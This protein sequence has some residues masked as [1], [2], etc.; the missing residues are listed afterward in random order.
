MQTRMMING[1]LE[2]G[3]G[4]RIPV[5]NPATG[6]ELVRIAEAGRDQVANA[7]AAADAA[8]PRWSRTAPK[9]RAAVLLQIR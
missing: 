4:E 8:L 9:D 5:F 7:V 3:L 6:A 2:V 1:Q